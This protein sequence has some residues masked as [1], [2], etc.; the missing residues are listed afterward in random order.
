MVLKLEFIEVSSFS[1]IRE[2]YFTDVEFHLLQLFLMGNP[3]AGSVVRGS[4]AFAN[5]DGEQGAEASAADYV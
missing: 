4:G 2:E 1:A 5:L 3:G